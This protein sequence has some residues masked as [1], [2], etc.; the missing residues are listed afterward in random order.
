MPKF[1]HELPNVKVLFETLAAGE[2]LLPLVVEKDSWGMHCL[3][4]GSVTL[5]YLGASWRNDAL[6]VLE[7]R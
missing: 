2:N 3:W 5:C 7:D 1:V 6:S 4:C